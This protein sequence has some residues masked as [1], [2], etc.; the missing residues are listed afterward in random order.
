MSRVDSGRECALLLLLVPMGVTPGIELGL[1]GMVCADI[2]A[3]PTELVIVWLVSVG[4]VS[5]E[6]YVDP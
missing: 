2:V 6:G 3:R 1:G 4:A 5:Q